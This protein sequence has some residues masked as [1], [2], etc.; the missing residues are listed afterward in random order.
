MQRGH[1]PLIMNMIDK[2]VSP[3]KRKRKYTDMRIV[4]IL[5]L[6]QIFHISYRS[7]AIFLGK[8]PEY[9]DMIGI[10]SIPSFQTI[11]RRARSIDMHEINSEIASLYMNGNMAAMD[12]FMIHTCKYSTASR[13]RRHG[14]YRDPESGWSKT[15]KGC[16]YGRKC[17]VSMDIDSLIISE[18]IITRGNIHDSKASHHLI[19]SVRDFQ[20][21]LADSAYDSAEIYDYIFENTHSLPVIDTNR[22]RGIRSEKL[23][24]NRKIGIDM[25]KNNSGMYSL[26]WE[27]ERTFS[28]LEEIMK[29]E[30]IWYVKERNY[31][32]AMGLK[33]IA[34]N[35]MVIS[36][37]ELGEKARAINKIVVC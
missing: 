1:I 8:H 13:R 17:H 37:I 4:K 29:S 2:I 10:S 18:W 3:D 26:R 31:D 6:L 16:S 24:M 23:G 12:S 9:M 5:M 36:N 11:S 19:D 33:I 25:R 21:I 14:K 35:L 20:Y 28:I 30:D 22:R 32:T 7:S 34:Y 27:I 15:T